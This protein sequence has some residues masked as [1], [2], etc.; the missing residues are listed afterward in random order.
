VQSACVGSADLDVTATRSDDGK[1]LALSVVNTG[2]AP[3]QASLSLNGF[4]GVLPQ[5]R[6]WTLAADLQAVNPPDGPETVRPQQSV[7]QSVRANFD[8]MFP[9]HSYTI[10]RLQR[11]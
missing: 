4:P 2:D 10:F 6:I 3:H 7:T 9:A 5:A 11:K 8:Y 1:T